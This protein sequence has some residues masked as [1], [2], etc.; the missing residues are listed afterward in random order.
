MLSSMHDDLIGKYETFQNAKNMWDQ[1][2]FDFGGTSTTRLRSLVL[3]FKVYRK[4]PKDT[5]NEHLRM[6]PRMIR[7]LKVAGNVLTDEQQ[8]QAI[9]RSLH[10]SWISMKIIMTHN[11]N[12]KNLLIYLVMWN[13][14]RNAKR[15]PNLQPLSPM[16]GS[17]NQMGLS[18]KTRA[19]QQDRVGLALV[20]PKS[21]RVQISTR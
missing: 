5:M 21:T 4:D 16:V 12:I 8:V 18:A 20:L 11:E 2:K 13:W 7:D 3:K 19:R 6:M 14:K 10:D 15:Q 9:I 17:V 1:L